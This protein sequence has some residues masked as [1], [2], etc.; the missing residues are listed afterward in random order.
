MT[1]EQALNHPYVKEFK[2]TEDE[3]NKGIN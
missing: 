1:V 3:S 2:G